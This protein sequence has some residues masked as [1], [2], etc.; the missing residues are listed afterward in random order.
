MLRIH[1][2]GV[3]LRNVT[4]AR[5]PDPLWELV[6]SLTV[7]Q[8]KDLPFRYYGWRCQAAAR[9]GACR[10]IDRQLMILRALVPAA[11]NFPDLL[12]PALSDSDRHARFEVLLSTPPETI[13]RDLVGAFQNRKP[14]PW[15]K[16]LARDNQRQSL[17]DAVA[18]LR[19]YEK[20]ALA[21][22][23]DTI[24]HA[25]ENDRALRAGQLLDHGL[26]GLFTN[27][28]PTTRWDGSTL[29]RDAAYEHTIQLAGRGLRLIP[30][31]FCFS[32]PISLIDVDLS[33]VLVYPIAAQAAAPHVAPD[34]ACDDGLA[35]LL[36]NTRSKVLT[37][38]DVAATT[39]QLAHRLG[40]SLPS[41]SQHLRTLRNAGLLT[42]QR[43]GQTVVHAITAQ[44]RILLDRG[45][46][47]G[48]E[49]ATSYEDVPN[50]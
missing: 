49:S 44:G 2:T 42:S 17:T 11:G 41:V 25:V 10:D 18:A 40:I 21:P 3:D 7:L 43:R 38:L 31:Y 6:L 35:A 36:G 20:H 50:W 26:D 8:D 34:P 30:S 13:R 48:G 24:Q 23:W 5:G 16:T 19:R 12:T 32:G 28:H 15:I 27:L 1:F 33:P 9:L 22:V 47:G 45:R 14:S 46:D 4:L 39:T 29:A 37:A